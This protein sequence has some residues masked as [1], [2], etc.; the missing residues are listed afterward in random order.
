MKKKLIWTV[1]ILL[2]LIGVVLVVA[3]SQSPS[4]PATYKGISLPTPAPRR[5]NY[6][7]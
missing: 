4:L 5:L 7:Q 3:Q 6:I 1:V 2:T